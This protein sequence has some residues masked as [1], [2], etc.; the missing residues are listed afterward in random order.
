M[1]TGESLVTVTIFMTMSLGASDTA[2]VPSPRFGKAL[3]AVRNRHAA[4]IRSEARVALK[5]NLMTYRTIR[6]NTRA[7]ARWSKH[8][9]LDQIFDFLA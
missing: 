3:S 6:R 5:R 4:R 1:S 8:A 9:K 7:D 2:A